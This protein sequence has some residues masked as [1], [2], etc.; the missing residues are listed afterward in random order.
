MLNQKTLKPSLFDKL[1][2][3]VTLKT[4]WKSMCRVTFQRK[5]SK[6][7]SRGQVRNDFMSKPPE[8]VLMDLINSPE[9]Y[10]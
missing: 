5:S 9:K 1:Q 3:E 10:F 4:V 8:Y 2:D 6:S 7:L